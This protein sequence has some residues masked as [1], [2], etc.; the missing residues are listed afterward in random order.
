MTHFFEYQ[1]WLVNSCMN[2]SLFCNNMTQHR[3]GRV[4]VHNK[5]RINRAQADDSILLLFRG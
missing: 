2:G 1:E 4:S 3:I 5:S